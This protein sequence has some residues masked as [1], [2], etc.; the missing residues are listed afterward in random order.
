[1]SNEIVES[2]VLDME[3]EL[4]VYEK[5]TASVDAAMERCANI[6]LCYDTKKDVESSR[7]WIF[8]NLNKLNPRINQAHKLGKAEA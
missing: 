5:V 1:M 7:S 6:I 2:E 3:V 8:Q 4:Q